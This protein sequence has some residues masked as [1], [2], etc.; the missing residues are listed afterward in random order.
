MDCSR[1]SIRQGAAEVTLVYRRDMKDMPASNEVHE[2]IEE[3]VQA[4][5]QAGPTRIITDEKTARSP[6]SS[7][8]ATSSA[9]RTRRAA[10]GPSRRPGTEFTIACDRVL[11]AIGQ[12]PDLDL[13]RARLG[14]PEATQAAPAQGRRR[15]VRDR[16]AGRLRHRRRPDRRGDRRPGDRR[17]PPRRLRR[18]RLPA[19]A[20]TSPRS[21]PAR[22]W[23]SR[24]PSSC[25]SCRSRARS[26]SRATGSRRW[27]AEVR[28]KSYVEY[29]IPYT[30]AEARR[31]VDPL[32]AVHLRGDR[33]LRPAPPR[34]RVRDDAADARAAVP[35]GRRLPE[36]HRE[37][38]HR[39]QPRLHP[40]RLPRVHPPRAVALHRLRPLRPGLLRGR[41]RGLLRLHAHR[42]RHAR[43]DAARH[44]PQ[45]HAV[46]VLRPL[47]RDVP[48][49]GAHAE[50]ARAPE[51]RGRREP[52]HPVRH[53][54]RRLPVRRPPR[55]RRV[56]ARPHEPGRADGRPHGPR[57]DRPRDRGH[58]HPPRARL[59]GPGD[60]RRAARSTSRPAAADPAG[61]S[62][63]T[64]GGHGQRP[65]QRPRARP[66]RQRRTG[67]HHGAWRDGRSRAA[68][69]ATARTERA[70]ADP[71][72]RA[73]LRA[74]AGTTSLFMVFAG[75]DDRGRRCSS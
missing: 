72:Y 23:P 25:R 17:G 43:H 52:L 29:E 8:S 75:D 27:T 66:R 19:R 60:R 68:G 18:R 22:R 2:A 36:R 40:R 55:R 12:G 62:R 37:P 1:T 5:F 7:S 44:E 46:R 13:D 59:G 45:R 50:A 61:R 34:D 24:S 21:G 11:L 16:P 70:G 69:A 38:L 28:N 63:P 35:P 57:R 74:S 42:L 31:R 30:P 41:R 39:H 33:V 67:R 10:G 32:P 71:G 58:L 65:R 15:D 47:R 53:L 4:I 56:R 6:A 48:D 64:G 3:G 9:S 73:R 51:V 14:G 20:S 54:R 49:R 26:R